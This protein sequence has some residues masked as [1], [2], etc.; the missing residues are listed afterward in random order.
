MPETPPTN[1]AEGMEEK[2]T[3]FYEK[4]RSLSLAALLELQKA[5]LG[6]GV[7]AN[8]RELLAHRSPEEQALMRSVVTA[9]LEER[10]NPPAGTVGGEVIEEGTSY[11]IK[12]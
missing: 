10:L 4:F 3:R 6:K 11:R 7:P 9:V 8:I 1:T 5:L 12:P 2:R